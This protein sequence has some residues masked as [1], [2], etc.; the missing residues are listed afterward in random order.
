MPTQLVVCYDDDRQLDA[1]AAEVN[2]LLFSFFLL[3]LLRTD[4]F[5]LFRKNN[6]DEAINADVGFAQLPVSI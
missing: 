1:W 5:F 2:L 6:A 3:T 4:V